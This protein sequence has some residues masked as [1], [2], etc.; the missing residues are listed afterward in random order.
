M[1]YIYKTVSVHVRPTNWTCWVFVQP[2]GN[3]SMVKPMGTGWQ[4]SDHHPSHKSFQTNAATFAIFVIIA[5]RFRLQNRDFLLRHSHVPMAS[6][7]KRLKHQIIQLFIIITGNSCVV[8]QNHFTI[9]EISRLHR[10]IQ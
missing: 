6:R 5:K 4:L 9:Q 7:G 10:F 8:I 2:L 3:A 1:I